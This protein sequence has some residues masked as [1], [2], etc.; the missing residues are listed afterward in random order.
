MAAHTPNT[1]E[2]V[3]EIVHRAIAGQTP[4]SVIGHATRDGI[5]RPGNT[6]D[7]L[8]TAAL[9]GIAMYEP[10]ELVFTAGAG[11]PLAEIEAA[12]AE[13]GQMLAFEPPHLARLLGKTEAPDEDAGTLGGM[14]AAGLAGPRR[15]R[16][17]GVR[18]HLLG[19]RAVNGRGEIFRSGG[20]VMK[21][22]TGYDLSKLM[23]GSWGTLAVLCELTFKVLPAPET[24]LTLVWQGLSEETA[25]ALMTAAMKTPWEVSAAAHLPQGPEGRN[26]RPLT[27]LRIEGFAR[28]VSARAEALARD[29]A[30]YGTP[31]RL[32]A[33]DSR[34]LWRQVR[35]VAPFWDTPA[36]TGIWRIS[37]PPA[38]GA[39]V[40]ADIRNALPDSTAFL[41]WAGGLIWLA[42][43]LGDDPEAARGIAAQVRAPLRQTGGHATLIRAP[44]DV[45]AMVDVFHPQPAPL[46]ALQERIRASFD[47]HRILEPGRMYPPPKE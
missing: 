47:P 2:A 13:R 5:G 1:I 26:E 24:E 11:T 41:D 30:E 8:C 37:C 38:T 12:L 46:A 35:D 4:L 22:V 45:R 42:T 3:A 31:E 10:E 34:R 23:C 32:Q 36:E 21:N 40:L 19:F 28:S 25:N 6:G 27:A 9:A 39:R 14:T 7:V 16:A 17:G 18:D 15:I 20:R 43:P 29:L 44:R 33:E